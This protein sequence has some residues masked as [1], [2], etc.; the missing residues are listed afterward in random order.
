MSDWS[1]TLE[2]AK[3]YGHKSGVSVIGTRRNRVK[4]RKGDKERVVALQDSIKEIDHMRFWPQNSVGL[5]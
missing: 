5:K 3:F 2:A 1:I 4:L